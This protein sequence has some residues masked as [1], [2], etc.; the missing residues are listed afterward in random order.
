MRKAVFGVCDQVRHKPACPAT[1]TSESPEIAMKE[2]WYLGSEQQKRW[3]V[4]LL[5]AYDMNRFSHDV[6]HKLVHNSRLSHYLIWRNCLFRWERLTWDKLNLLPSKQTSVILYF[7]MPPT[8]KRSWRGILLWG[9]P[10]VHSFVRLFDAC[11]ILWTVLAR[12]LTF[13]IWIPHEK[14][15]RPTF[16]SCPSYAPS[17]KIRIKSC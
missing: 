2:T 14:N 7:F 8:S 9:C 15:T 16:F 3:S 6:A 13:H 12:V 10:S 1:Q 17:K 4:P 5:F 11:H